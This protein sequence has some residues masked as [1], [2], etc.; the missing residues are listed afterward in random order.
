MAK[1]LKWLCMPVAFTLLRFLFLLPLW[2]PHQQPGNADA[3][4]WP[5]PHTVRWLWSSSLLHGS[6]L[7]VLTQMSMKLLPPIRWPHA[8]YIAMGAVGAEAAAQMLLFVIHGPRATN[9]VFL[10]IAIPAYVATLLISTT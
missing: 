9:G 2:I 8:L 7:L 5:D 10:L 1:L 3:F 6:V 4:P